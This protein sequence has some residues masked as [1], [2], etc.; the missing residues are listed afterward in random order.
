MV[1]LYWFNSNVRKA[2]TRR[3]NNRRKNLK[4]IIF[5]LLFRFRDKF[6]PF[7]RIC[8]HFHR[9]VL[10]S[11]LRSS[12]GLYPSL[13]MYSSG[14]TSS[15]RR[16]W[17]QI[18]ILRLFIYFFGFRWSSKRPFSVAN[19]L[20]HVPIFVLEGVKLNIY[21]FLFLSFSSMKMCTWYTHASY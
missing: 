20:S 6:S 3:S 2:C 15:L 1:L 21:S 17:V 18:Y 12:V 13:S 16:L 8:V 10:I 7:S 9:F 5:F 14:N 19:Q 11:V 4:L